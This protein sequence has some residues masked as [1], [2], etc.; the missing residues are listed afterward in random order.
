MFAKIKSEDSGITSYE[1]L[2][3][4]KKPILN[5]DEVKIMPALEDPSKRYFLRL[6]HHLFSFVDP[7][8]DV[9]KEY[10]AFKI[11]D[12]LSS[13]AADS[14]PRHHQNSHFLSN[15]N[16]FIDT[17][18]KDK[19]DCAELTKIIHDS[20]DI[21]DETLADKQLFNLSARR[22]QLLSNIATL[23]EQKSAIDKKAQARANFMFSSIFLAFF[24]EFLVGYYCIY[25]VE[26]LGW[27]LV[28]PVTYTLGQGKF[29]LG[30]WFF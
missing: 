9:L 26:W 24:T 23:E 5:I 16:L 20:L 15:M 8:V 10:E 27:D 30:T 1:F 22:L 3:P 19:I 7:T 18:S 17:S 4:Q 13:Q 6:N 25:Q 29:V 14:K 21:F 11:P 12:F 2:D 28:E